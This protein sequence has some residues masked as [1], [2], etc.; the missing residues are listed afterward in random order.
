MSTLANNVIKDVIANRPAFGVA[1]RLF[2][3]TDTGATYRD[4]GSSWDLYTGAMG[5][6]NTAGRPAITTV[7]AYYYDTTLNIPVWWDGANWRNA[8]G[9][10]S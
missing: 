10:I 5:S 4:S 1:G 3:A 2:F 7:G 6:G 8:S 9:V